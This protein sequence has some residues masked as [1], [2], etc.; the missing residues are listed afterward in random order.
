M[1]SGT[2]RP[3][4]NRIFRFL[5]IHN[6][7]AFYP[8]RKFFFADVH[9]MKRR[10]RWE[11]KNFDDMGTWRSKYQKRKR[12][13]GWKAGKIGMTTPHLNSRFAFRN[14][15]TSYRWRNT[16]NRLALLQLRTIYWKKSFSY[17][18]PGCGIAYQVTLVQQRLNM[19][20]KCT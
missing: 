3:Q 1:I 7:I 12:R 14:D 19:I 15:I 18:E 5:N 8:N 16:E 17:R 2:G 6:K 20:L 11:N 4:E 13:I 10:I 9:C